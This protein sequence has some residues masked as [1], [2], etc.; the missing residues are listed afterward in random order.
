[1]ILGLADAGK[2]AVAA[3]ATSVLVF[4]AQFLAKFIHAPAA[5]LLEHV[6]M[7]EQERDEA[8]A[9]LARY[10][11][12]PRFAV[13][14]E[15]A[16]F[17]ADANVKRTYIVLPL[18]V[19]NEGEPGSAFGWLVKARLVNGGEI[20]FEPLRIPQFNS[21]GRLAASINRA[22]TIWE[23]TVKLIERG[24]TVFGYYIGALDGADV[25]AQL[26]QSSLEISWTDYRNRQSR[27]NV[28]ASTVGTLPA[29]TM[30]PTLSPYD[31]L[32][33]ADSGPSPKKEP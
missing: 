30:P 29:R 25:V 8:K 12:G 16:S 17:S 11:E 26:Y 3:A 13:A 27:V 32:P 31:M 14:V 6:G 21:T 15:S 1:M 18:Q 28:L 20:T 7:V 9:R 22:E 33:G 23:R 2:V 4:A 5:I 24:E 10:E 19:T